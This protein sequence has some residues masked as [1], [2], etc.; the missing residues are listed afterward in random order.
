MRFLLA[1]QTFSM[2]RKHFIAMFVLAQFNVTPN[3]TNC[4]IPH[5]IYTFG[6]YTI[7]FFLPMEIFQWNFCRVFCFLDGSAFTKYITSQRTLS[8]S[9]YWNILY[10]FFHFYTIGVAT[11]SMSI[12]WKT[13]L[14]RNEEKTKTKYAYVCPDP[15]NTVINYARPHS[16]SL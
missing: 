13:L 1:F 12:F 14:L 4:L 15:I 8:M 7:F 9:F 5:Q 16:N 3:L 11:H 10:I 2:P 6:T